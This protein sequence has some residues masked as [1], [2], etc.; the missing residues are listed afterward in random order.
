MNKYGEIRDKIKSGVH[1]AGMS[2]IKELFGD[3]GDE[4]FRRAFTGDVE[5]A[6]RLVDNHTTNASV[7]FMRSGVDQKYRGYV[8]RHVSVD[9]RPSAA[10][11]MALL[12]HL[13]D[14]G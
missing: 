9:A 2:E 13:T 3:L 12:D 7:G 4:Q 6:I 11:L 10:I 14:Y 8:N 5:A 1:P